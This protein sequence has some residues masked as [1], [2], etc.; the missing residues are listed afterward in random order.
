M[1]TENIPGLDDL[2]SS[3]TATGQDAIKR[4][5][6]A[7]AERAALEAKHRLVTIGA[8][9]ALRRIV[10]D[11]RE[12]DEERQQLASITGNTVPALDPASAPAPTQQPAT[13]AQPTTP[14]PAPT[15]TQQLPA[16]PRVRVNHFDVRLWSVAQKIVAVICGLIG[17]FIASKTYDFPGYHNST[18]K[19]VFA[20]IW[21]VA[22]TALGFFAGGYGYLVAKRKLRNRRNG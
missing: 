9:A 10:D 1:T 18:G 13:P 7:N 8:A 20:I 21:T 14:D 16:T 12:L 11:V 6:Q 2:I 5:N 17:L 15:T 19:V 22:L 4:Q 3:L